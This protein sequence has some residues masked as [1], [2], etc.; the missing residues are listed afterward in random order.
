MDF[1]T[2]LTRLPKVDIHCH[3]VGTLRPGTL[4]ELARKHGVP[5][6]R[7]DDVIYDFEDF[8]SFL[9]ILRL[10]ATVMRHAEDFARV[11][12]EALQDGF[13]DGNLRHAE[14]MF[15]PQYFYASG[16]R[17]RTMVDGLI[18][19][20]R[21]ASKDF[22][23]TCLLIPSIDRQIEPAHALEIMDDILA[24]RPEEVVGIGLDG[25]ERAG[26]PERF[27]EVYRRAGQAGLMRT[28]HVCED[29]QTLAEAPAKHFATCCD[30]LRCD[31]IDHGYNL[32]ADAQMVARAR[33]SGLFFNTCPIT[34]VRRNIPRRHASIAR[35][36][37]LGL[38]VT[39][40]TDDPR[41]FKTDIGHSFRVLFETHNWGKD[42]AI[43]LSLAGVEACWLPESARA[44]LR[45]EFERQ[46]AA[47]DIEYRNG[48]ANP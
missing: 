28:A 17:Y 44:D 11:A 31:R 2:F 19:G 4:G 3:L 14:L 40:N 29:N 32:L 7:A 12:Y 35:M 33:E 6:P 18:D 10:S 36:R 47:L 43:A 16:V 22:G 45:R 42:I 27:Y 41:M 1:A 39:L 15:N 48:E 25:P 5:L 9:E 26:P 21:A 24:C 8:Y 34:S 13:R 30:V 23:T 38:K 46:I 37:E 20:V